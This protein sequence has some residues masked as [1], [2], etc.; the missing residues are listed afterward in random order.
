MREI[1]LDTETTGLNPREG[2]R[3]L[4]IACLEL[5]HQVPT[6]KTFYTLIDPERDVPEEA[7]RIHGIT[8]N[9]L[10]GQPRFKQIADDFLAFI[11]DDPLVIHN[12][13]FDMRFINHELARAR[14]PEIRFERA[15]D[16]LMMAQRKFPGAPASLD[17]L[18]RRFS[19]DNSARL[20]HG[21]LLD[22]ELLAEVYVNLLGGRQANLGFSMEVSRGGGLAMR[23]D[24]PVREPRPH[25]PTAQE[26]AAHA[27]F[28]AGIK[29]ALWN[30]A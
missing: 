19:V 26:L 9:K 2:H 21:A 28:V 3:I 17:A 13:S 15:V 23:S 7:A 12:A 1:V 22:C 14:R 16:T 6:G 29:D 27:R 18:C 4:E 11:G 5:V 8:A 10:V 24:R 25:A 20:F 30:A